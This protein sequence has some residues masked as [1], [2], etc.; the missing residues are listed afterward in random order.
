M[1]IKNIKIR[2]PRAA[3]HRGHPRQQGARRPSA[4]CAAP[5]SSPATP[6]ASPEARRPWRRT[7]SFRPARRP[8]SVEL[9]DNFTRTQGPRRPRRTL[10]RA[11]GHT[12][13]LEC[14]YCSSVPGLGLSIGTPGSGHAPLRL[15]PGLGRPTR[16][17]SS[18]EQLAKSTVK[19]V[20]RTRL[21]C[22]GVCLIFHGTSSKIK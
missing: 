8:R 10:R 19:L 12:V 2:K 15:G 4:A 3:A 11:G 16:A 17:P 6:S 22:S 21:R 1:K 5:I 20:I 9:L 18:I 7:D 14:L 13:G